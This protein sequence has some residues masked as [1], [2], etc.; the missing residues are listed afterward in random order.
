[1]KTSK[2]GGTQYFEGNDRSSSRMWLRLRRVVPLVAGSLAAGAAGCFFLQWSQGRE[3]EYVGTLVAF[4]AR[5]SQ[6]GE[7]RIDSRRAALPNTEEP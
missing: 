7:R 6:L 4:L 1:M 2:V 5:Q 3:T